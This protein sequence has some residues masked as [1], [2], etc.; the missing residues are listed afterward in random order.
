MLTKSQKTSQF[1]LFA[2]FHQAGSDR[3]SQEWFLC[4]PR[5]APH[6][7][8]PPAARSPRPNTRSQPPSQVSEWRRPSRSLGQPAARPC[9]PPLAAPRP[10][11]TSTLPRRGAAAR[12]LPSRALPPLRGSDRSSPGG[13]RSRPAAAAAVHALASAQR[14]AKSKAL[15]AA[16]QDV[17]RTLTRTVDPTDPQDIAKAMLPHYGWSS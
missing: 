4:P 8:E 6:A 15:P 13:L 1:A 12:L 7:T 14:A 17:S 11:Q 2:H 16:Q 9:L 3:L 5:T 10:R